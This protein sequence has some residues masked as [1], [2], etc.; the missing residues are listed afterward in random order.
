MKKI[1][2]VLGLFLMAGSLLA[3]TDRKSPGRCS[4]KRVATTDARKSVTATTYTGS[5]IAS[6]LQ[7]DGQITDGPSQ[8]I[9]IDSAAIKRTGANTVS[10]ILSQSGTRR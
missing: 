7:V 5:H 9:I 10:Q 4:R 1:S 3:G 2:L 6:R 8:L